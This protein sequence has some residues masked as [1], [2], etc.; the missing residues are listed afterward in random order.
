[1]K[2]GA[3]YWQWRVA[4]EVEDVAALSMRLSVSMRPWPRAKVVPR[5]GHKQRQWFNS[6]AAD[7]TLRAV[8]RRLLTCAWRVNQ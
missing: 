8:K 3:V 5:S 4:H 6:P 7:N 2:V 1:M